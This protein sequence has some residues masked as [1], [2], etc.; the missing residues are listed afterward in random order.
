[1]VEYELLLTITSSTKTKMYKA[2]VEAIIVNSDIP[3]IFLLN[4]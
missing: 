3:Y 1:M 4:T 2:L